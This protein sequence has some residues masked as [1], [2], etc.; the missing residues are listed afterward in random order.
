M[1]DL[2]SS[3]PKKGLKY[4]PRATMQKLARTGNLKSV[5]TKSRKEDATQ[6]RD[7]L[8]PVSGSR[9]LPTRPV[10]GDGLV[11]EPNGVD[12][13]YRLDS[14]ALESVLS[15]NLESDFPNAVTVCGGGYAAPSAQAITAGMRFGYGLICREISAIKNIGA[16]AW[17]QNQINTPL[18]EV[19]PGLHT[20]QQIWDAFFD[21]SAP[22]SGIVGTVEQRINWVVQYWKDQISL[23]NY[24]GITGNNPFMAR[25]ARFWDQY[26]GI[27][28]KIGPDAGHYTIFMDGNRPLGFY[29]SVVLP[30]VQRTFADMLIAAADS[31]EMMAHLDGSYAAT[32]AVRGSDGYLRSQPL[33]NPIQN[34][35]RELLQIHT[36]TD[37]SFNHSF[38]IQEGLVSA[39]VAN[40]VFRDSNIQNQIDPRT[41]GVLRK[42]DMDDVREV[43]WFLGGRGRGFD[44]QIY[45]FSSGVV[46]GQF[47]G[48]GDYPVDWNL[49]QEVPGVYSGYNCAHFTP[50][51][52]YHFKF[53]NYKVG[54]YYYNA[55]QP[56][57]EL[58]PE[59]DYSNYTNARRAIIQRQRMFFRKL[60]M[61]PATATNVC[62]HLI[63]HFISADSTATNIRPLLKEMVKAWMLS[64]GD[65]KEVYR[66]MVSH[67]IALAPAPTTVPAI[68]DPELVLLTSY[69]CFGMIQGV[70]S[71][72]FNI[73][74]AT[75]MSAND[76]AKL[77]ELFYSIL[78]SLGMHPTNAPT[79]QGWLW[80]GGDAHWLSPMQLSLRMKQA[81]MIATQIASTADPRELYYRLIGAHANPSLNASSVLQNPDPIS[82]IASIMMAYEFQTV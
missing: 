7:S 17:L 46:G 77:G 54:S 28:G 4:I 47:P 32:G 5:L 45:I 10:L 42:Y 58:F 41:P 60:A 48:E 8:K 39:S 1:K 35:A 76:R 31:A 9:P 27:S 18:T 15:N 20:G 12:V 33:A 72:P 44:P 29:K 14:K 40:Y 66:A 2:D 50:A 25:M 78:P 64:G 59:S 71:G 37:D 80:H 56:G 30:N 6:L 62:R 49:A 38:A 3:M 16:V 53:L 24:Q 65:L 73:S 34:Y 26:W 22:V 36:V 79:V 61:H 11:V 19:G 52:P 23:R 51:R 75:Q 67:P 82:A 55:P 43:A 68:K 13:D 74:N 81:L 63:E 70:A 21:T 69:R 57:D